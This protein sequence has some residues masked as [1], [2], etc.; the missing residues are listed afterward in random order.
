[1]HN[2]KILVI[3]NEQA[4]QELIRC[5]FESTEND[6]QIFIASNLKE[7]RDYLKKIRPSIALINYSLPDGKGIEF[8]LQKEKAGS[9]VFPVII[10][11]HMWDE[12]AAV[13]SIKSGALDYLVK[14]QEN[15]KSLPRLSKRV[16]REWQL[17]KNEKQA[18][19]KEKLAL[20]ILKLL[21]NSPGKIELISQILFLI[22]N[23][24][25]FGAVGIRLKVGDDFPYFEA[26]GFPAKFIEQE[27]NL[28]SIDESKKIVKDS[29]GWTD[30]ECT[31]GNIICGRTDPTREFFTEGG[32]FWTN[33]TTKLMASISETDYQGR[34][35]NRCNTEG[36]E[37]VALIPLRS[38]DK[39]IGLLQIND[40]RKYIF[41]EELI[42]FFEGLGNSIGIA[43]DRNNA[44][45]I[46]KSSE[47]RV[48]KLFEE[49]GDAIFFHDLD[50]N[51]IEVNNTAC[52]SL[53]Y[54]KERFK[55]LHLQDIFA[56]ENREDISL[57][58]QNILQ[59]KSMVFESTYQTQSGRKFPVE[60]NAC[61]V[62]DFPQG[63]AVLNI[64]RD[65]SKRIKFREQLIQADKMKSMGTLVAGLAHEI[66]N[67]NNAIMMNT[68]LMDEIWKGIAPLLEQYYQENGDFSIAGLPFKNLKEEVPRLISGS[69]KSS[70]KINY[71]VQK[72]R[73]FAKK[74]VS[75][76]VELDPN[77]I[78]KSAVELTRNL[79]KKVTMNFSVIYGK[80]IPTIMGTSQGLEQVLINLLT[81][82]C[83]SLADNTKSISL[84]SS[85]DSE[86][87]SVL[88]KCS[89][90]G[91][92]IDEK[93]LFKITAPFYS[94]KR[95]I[96]N[97]G[98]GLSISY[99]I[100]KSY[101]GTLE[102][103][104]QPGKGTTAIVK[105]P[106]K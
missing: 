106:V 8:L 54:S 33:S 84:S 32:S 12:S 94:T 16:I 92:G 38:K 21:N 91:H 63:P 14:S 7:G 5:S 72:L 13:E 17:I 51:F 20:E 65:M 43:I 27:N 78:V 11:S 22:K 10:M 74:G 40:R 24:M 4:H 64:A 28:C 55:E 93:E 103:I 85:F 31:C 86:S 37:S 77:S 9:Q 60:I 57:L 52:E 97:S 19:K 35:R 41:T 88:I 46:L 98:L 101:N 104:S 53:G 58:Q 56:A 3:E 102:F 6:F 34:L 66:N 68:S 47:S 90:E 59:K 96:G 99:E 30:L 83:Q 26:S 44:E 87:K 2:N 29:K 79:I 89:D 1:M 82:S 81:N 49:A 75:E 69:G 76:K 73:N 62:E 95:E 39:T 48:R 70:A 71:I 25:E 23:E 50:G 80:D 45:I 100:V 67:P 36:Y 42:Q 105:L 61:L 18:K 15:L